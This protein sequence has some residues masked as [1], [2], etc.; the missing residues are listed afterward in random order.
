MQVRGNRTTNKNEIF[1]DE[2]G[3]TTHQIQAVSGPDDWSTHESNTV[4]KI[5]GHCFLS[6]ILS[7]TIVWPTF[8]IIF[9]DIC[10]PLQPLN[11]S[12]SIDKKKMDNLTLTLY[13][14]FNRDLD[15]DFDPN[16]CHRLKIFIDYFPRRDLNL[17][18]GLFN[19]WCC[20]TKNI[21]NFSF[22]IQI[23]HSN[24]PNIFTSYIHGVCIFCMHFRICYRTA[25]PYYVR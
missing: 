10:F 5:T 1:K 6:V 19:S 25:A 4:W 2:R 13:P 22:Q 17:L 14:S 8:S 20:K 9:S 11:V 24:I 23:T 16:E 21:Q 12:Q 3:N 15:V 7:R 18:L